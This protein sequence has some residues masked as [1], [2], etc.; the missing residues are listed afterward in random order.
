MAG[1]GLCEDA[2]TGDADSCTSASAGAI[3]AS[4]SDSLSAVDIVS[5]RG[6]G[7]VPYS[8]ATQLEVGMHRFTLFRSITC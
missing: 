5:R 1:A 3:A 4:D 6:S 2:A 8:G 7:Q